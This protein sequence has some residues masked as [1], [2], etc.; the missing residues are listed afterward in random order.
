MS[1]RLKTLLIATGAG[2]LALLVGVPLAML[3]VVLGGTTTDAVAAVSTCSISGTAETTSDLDAEQTK[4]ARILI[5]VGKSEEVPPRGWVV[6]ISAAL[7]E[8]GMRNLP[9]GDRDSLG[10][11]QQRPS[12]GWG[13]PKEVVNPA[14]AA[15]AFYGGPH[16][17]T[18]NAGLLS[19]KG[20]QD[21]PVWQAAQRVQR[22][23]FPFAYEKHEA[24]ATRVV[25]EL[26]GA[27]G[28]CTPLQSGPWGLPVSAGYSLTSGF[29]GR[30]SPTKGTQDFHT[31]QDFAVPSG[32][33]ALAVSTGTVSFAGWSGGYGNLVCVRHA[34][35]VESYYGHLLGI[36]V[37]KG[38]RVAGG[39]VLGRTG[40]TGN[41]T[42]PHLHL[43]IR[44][45]GR[46][47]DPLPWLR[48]RGAKP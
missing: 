21:M 35:G 10:I 39:T 8:S 23:A 14:Y 15:K 41:S 37:H 30:I 20:W 13:S 19:V 1:R 22:S 18:S 43:E 26:S 4:N 47:A 44:V 40:S 45:D 46:P 7:Q 6:A 31:G 34:N 33:S 16:S 29:G 38:D 36:E 42:G 3:A 11:M 5:A 17:P 25:K 28:G 12:A 9:Y 32:T 2:S 27:T 24:L 48:S